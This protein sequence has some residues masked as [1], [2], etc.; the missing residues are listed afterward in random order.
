M[1]GG[2]SVAAVRAR[3]AVA[4]VR[5]ASDECDRRVSAQLVV[6]LHQMPNSD[7]NLH[8][9]PEDDEDDR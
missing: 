8:D 3:C 5:P 6:F 9:M 4:T 7:A 2:S 1:P